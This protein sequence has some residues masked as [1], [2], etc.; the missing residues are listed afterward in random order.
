MGQKISRLMPVLVITDEQAIELSLTMFTTAKSRSNTNGQPSIAIIT[1]T[2]DV[3]PQEVYM[4][5]RTAK[6]HE[7]LLPNIRVVEFDGSGFYGNAPTSTR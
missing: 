1:L 7:P 6:R 4:R 5:W 3:E 2:H